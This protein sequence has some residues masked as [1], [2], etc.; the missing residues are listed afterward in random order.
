MRT[1]R[2]IAAIESHFRLPE[3]G[4]IGRLV[5]DFQKSPLSEALATLAQQPSSLQTAMEQ[6]AT[7]WLHAQE[8]IRSIAGFAELQGI[9][10]ALRSVAGFDDNLAAA[11]RAD[12]GDWRDPISWRADVLNDLNVR[13][14]FYADLGFNHALTAFPAPAFAESLD[15]TGLRCEPPPPMARYGPPVPF[16]DDEEQEDGFE[17]ANLAHNWLQRLETQLRAFIDE[18]MTRAFGA[19]WPRHRLPNGMYDQWRA[20]KR[21]GQESG[22]AEWPL[23]TYADFTDYVLVICRGDNWREVFAAFFRRPESVRE[24]FQRLH[25]IRLDTMHARPITQDDELLLYVETRRLAKM[26]RGD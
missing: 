15:I 17:R 5:S 19:D 13:A 18:Q 12:L 10:Q 20:K 11:L 8:T 7:P 6:M 3:L 22:A 14:G 26:I 2:A 25:P 4:E 23:I 16:P 24:S 1:T 21:K 9:G